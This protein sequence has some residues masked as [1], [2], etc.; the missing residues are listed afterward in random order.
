[1]STPLFDI[2]DI[3]NRVKARLGAQVREMEITD[4]AIY[5]ILMN[6]TLQTLQVYFP[7]TGVVV[8]NPTTDVVPY[9][10]SNIFY[11][12]TDETV[13][14]VVSV[15]GMSDG[16]SDSGIYNDF[17]FN[18][19]NIDPSNFILYNA[20]REIADANSLPY[21]AVMMPPNMVR[22]NPRPRGG[23]VVLRVNVAHKDFSRIHPGLREYVMRLAE[24][25]VK[26]DI[27]GI[28]QYFSQINTG[29][30]SIE[31]NLGS[32]QDAEQ[33]R[34]ELIQTFR[35]RRQFSSNRKKLWYM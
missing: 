20:Q 19:Y 28:R 3:I 6:E 30:D 12:R 1:M 34:E 25:D 33:K 27:L 17:R 4:S 11:L 35:E 5:D 10:E 2:T 22:I 26:M 16:V 24:Y 9:E 29:F 7:D 14:N 18:Q 32:F 8:V 15:I 13:I 23:S 31:L 21:T